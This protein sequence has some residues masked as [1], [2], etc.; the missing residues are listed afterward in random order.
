MTRL[1]YTSSNDHVFVTNKLGEPVA[2]IGKQILIFYYLIEK[3]GDSG[4]YITM[5][6][7]EFRSTLDE[8][9][10]SILKDKNHAIYKFTSRLNGMFNGRGEFSNAISNLIVRKLITECKVDGPEKNLYMYQLNKFSIKEHVLFS[11]KP[12]PESYKIKNRD[13]VKLYNKKYHDKNR[14]ELNEKKRI[15]YQVEKEERRKIREEKQKEKELR[16]LEERRI[17]EEKA[18][19][20]QKLK[21]ARELEKLKKRKEKEFQNLLKKTTGKKPST[22][23]LIKRDTGVMIDPTKVVGSSNAIVNEKP[24]V[25]SAS[26]STTRL[27]QGYTPYQ[28]SSK[29]K[30]KEVFIHGGQRAMAPNA[31]TPPP[32]RE[33]KPRYVTKTMREKGN[34]YNIAPTELEGMIKDF[35]NKGNKIKVYDQVSEDIKAVLKGPDRKLILSRK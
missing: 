33:I 21:E 25:M 2:V 26:S 10:N 4:G 30:T 17:K 7:K 15:K 27:N 34:V 14:E 31:K 29:H 20:K 12:K 13:K 23:K 35:I 19:E 3:L 1:V 8:Y 32:K 22:K 6:R 9:Y 24:V 5:S 16:L 11:D 28:V 18:L